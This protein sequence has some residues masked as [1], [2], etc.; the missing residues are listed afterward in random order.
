MSKRKKIEFLD[1]KIS[2]HIPDTAMVTISH[3]ISGIDDEVRWH[4]RYPLF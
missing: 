4:E 2:W 3:N 1:S